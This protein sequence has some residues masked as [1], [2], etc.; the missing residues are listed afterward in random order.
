MHTLEL[1]PGGGGEESHSAAATAV[2]RAGRAAFLGLWLAVASG[3]STR[4]RPVQRPATALCC[5]LWSCSLSTV[6]AFLR[7]NHLHA[8]DAASLAN[9]RACGARG[10]G[11][12]HAT[13]SRNLS[14]DN[15]AWVHALCFLATTDW[16]NARREGGR[17]EG[18]GGRGGVGGD[19][20]GGR[21]VN[22]RCRRRTE[23]RRKAEAEG[24]L[25][26]YARV[27]G[28]TMNVVVVAAAAGEALPSKFPRAA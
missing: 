12:N 27:S 20:T 6:H 19:G 10:T 5:L 14:C 13:Y 18:G 4:Q 21:A 22:R 15:D 7:T 16:G 2:G 3:R 25:F 28:R 23:R 24:A 9:H 1:L 11:R 26:S 17:R 8:F